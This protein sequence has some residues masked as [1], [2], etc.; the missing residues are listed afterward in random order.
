MAIHLIHDGETVRIDLCET[1]AQGKTLRRTIG[2]IKGIALIQRLCHAENERAVYNL[3]DACGG[4][5][6]NIAAQSLEETPVC[7]APGCRNKPQWEYRC[8][9]GGQDV[10]F[11]QR[12][13][14]PGR[15][16]ACYMHVLGLLQNDEVSDPG[17]E[18]VI[19]TY[20]PEKEDN[21]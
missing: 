7:A 9:Q 5:V 19:R 14:P 15:K 13:A 20:R 4:L 3:Y 21:S 8:Y 18:R 10:S 12:E 17:R 1:S 2:S 11:K 6:V 16:L